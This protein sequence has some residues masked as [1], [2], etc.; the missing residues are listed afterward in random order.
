M[1][2]WRKMEISCTDH[3]KKKKYYVS[4]IKA[5]CPTYKEKKDG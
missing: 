2:W 4:L 1:W 3:A 5:K